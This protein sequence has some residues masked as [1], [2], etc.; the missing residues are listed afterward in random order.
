MP[1]TTSQKR[2]PH[3]AQA[4][5]LG[6]A[7]LALTAGRANAAPLVKECSKNG[8]FIIGFSQANNAEPY[9]QHVNDDLTALPRR[10][11]NSPCKSPMAPVT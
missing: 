7:A 3:V 8:Q 6:V 10:S 11:R 1:C 5:L 9:R 2:H 4:L